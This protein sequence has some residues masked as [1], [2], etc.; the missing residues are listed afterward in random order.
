MKVID[1]IEDVLRQE[2]ELLLSG[3]YAALDALVE[4]KS[5]LVDRLRDHKTMVSGAAVEA[6]AIRATENEALLGAAQRG[7][8][9]ALSQLR[10]F[11]AAERQTTYTRQGERFPLSPNRSSVTQKL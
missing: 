3:N 10:P 9:A 4:R 5:R 6:L 7:L 2:Q 8:K 11:A 1:E